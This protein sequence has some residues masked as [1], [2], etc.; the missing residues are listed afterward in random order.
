M[1]KKTFQYTHDTMR[2]LQK[3]GRKCCNMWQ[4][5]SFRSIYIITARCWVIQIRKEIGFL[6]CLW[7]NEHSWQA[8][9]LPAVVPGAGVECWSSSFL[10]NKSLPIRKRQVVALVP[11]LVFLCIFL[12]LAVLIMQRLHDLQRDFSCPVTSL[13]GHCAFA[14]VSVTFST[15]CTFWTVQK[16]YSILVYLLVNVPSLTHSSLCL[17]SVFCVTPIFKQP[18]NFRIVLD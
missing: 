15:S 11:L 8:L 16:P 18:F 14:L 7:P 17:P 4:P 10:Q 13:M 5:Y 12:L 9:I 1:M 3:K 6:L 2:L